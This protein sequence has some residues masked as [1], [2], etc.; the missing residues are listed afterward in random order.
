MNSFNSK[1]SL[2]VGQREYEIYR[3]SALDKAKVCA[4]ARLPF[5]LRVLLENL[6]RTENGRSVTN[7]DIL[8]LVNWD[9]ER[10]RFHSGARAHAGFHRRS[11]H[12]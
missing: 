5:S 11:R 12:R 1:S 9:L 2:R 6:L 8:A 3:I 7:E 10:D 4:T